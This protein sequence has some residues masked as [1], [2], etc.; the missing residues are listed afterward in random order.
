MEKIEEIAKD[1]DVVKIVGKIFAKQKS[2]QALC[3]EVWFL[4]AENGKFV[5][6]IATE[7]N[8]I[9]EIEKEFN[10]INLISKQICMP[11]ILLYKKTDNSAYFIMEHIDGKNPKIFSDDVLKKIANTLKNIHKINCGQKYVDYDNLLDIAEKNMKENRLDLSEF[12]NYKY[13]KKP[14]EILDW[15]M[16]NKPK[17]KACLCHGDFRPKNLIV[18]QSELFVLDWGLCFF[19]DPY[20]DIAMI[21]YYFSD[22]EFAAFCKFYGILKI[23]E[24]RIKY[25][26]WLSA[27]LNV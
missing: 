24:K 10:V 11:K 17:T 7:K 2:H 21:K 26:E 14:Q 15:L 23:D 12:V 20:Y 1:L 27:F 19:G 18:T 8:R 13:N 16:K 22:E 4:D 5:A 3:N 9:N 6:K 25:N